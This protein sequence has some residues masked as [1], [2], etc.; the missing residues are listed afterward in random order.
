MIWLI[1]QKRS[2]F[3]K[4]LG[5]NCK[6][7]NRII[8]YSTFNML[9]EEWSWLIIYFNDLFINKKDLFASVVVVQLLTHVRLFVTPWTATHQASLSFTVSLSLLKLMS[10]ESVMPSNY[11]IL[12]RPLLLLFS[13]FSSIRVFSSD[14]ALQIR[15]PKYWSFS[16]SISP[17]NEHSGEFPLGLTSL[18]TL[19]SKG[20]SRIF[21][22]TTVQKHPFF[23]TQLSL[24][25]IV[26]VN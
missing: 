15:W 11:L 20:L 3:E 17:S 1:Y 19:Q 23:C 22:N 12:C 16:F 25:P 26:N 10:I 13:I 8:K 24:W 7:F 21:H 4:A 6:L 5:V 9:L 14:L 2:W 18:I